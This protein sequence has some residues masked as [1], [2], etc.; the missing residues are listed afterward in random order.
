MRRAAAENKEPFMREIW[1]RIRETHARGLDCVVC[2]VAHTRGST[3]QKPGATMV[4]FPDGTQA[5]TLGGGCV[6]AEVRQRALTLLETDRPAVL[7][8]TLDDDYGWDDG[9]ICGGKMVFVA[10]PIHARQPLG[11]WDILAKLWQS[12]AGFTEALATNQL[13]GLPAGSRYLFSDQGLPLAAH[14]AE[15]FPQV[16]ADGLLPLED[17]PRPYSRAGIAYLPRLPRCRILIVGAGHVGQAI[18]ELADTVD[19]GVWVVDDREKFACRA[20]FPRAEQIVVGDIAAT[21]KDIAVDSSTYCLVVTRGH[22]HD[23]EALYHLV[24][25][26]W[27]YLGMIGSRRK[28]RLIFSDLARQGIPA[29]RLEQVHAPIGLSIGSQTVPEIAISVM[30][31]LIGHRNLGADAFPPPDHP[32]AVPASA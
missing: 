13:N 15:D 5:G 21:L 14:R 26:P 2:T 4:V 18:A 3:P 12:N 25:K 9:L 8:Y 32:R 1:A 11:Y 6:E 10:E 29:D 27:R 31:Q 23:E 30:A 24:M 7:E 17:R 28:I 16:V 19:F 22:S 20:R